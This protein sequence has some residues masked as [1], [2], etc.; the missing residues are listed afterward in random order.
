VVASGSLD[1]TITL[2]LQGRDGSRR[3]WTCTPPTAMGEPP[4][5]SLQ[6]METP[7]LTGPSA[8]MQIG[9]K[10]VD[11]EG[12]VLTVGTV[13]DIDSALFI[14]EHDLTAICGTENILMVGDLKDNVLSL[15]TH[16]GDVPWEISEGE[17]GHAESDTNAQEVC[18]RAFTVRGLEGTLALVVLS[19]VIMILTV[20]E[21][22]ET[23]GPNFRNPDSIQDC[24]KV[25]H[26]D[27]KVREIKAGTS[28]TLFFGLRGGGGGASRQ[29]GTKRNQR[30]R[31]MNFFRTCL[32]TI[33]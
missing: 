18:C 30:L 1:F 19:P 6:V 33:T 17:D 12:R 27:T 5:I 20:G 7:S 22:M 24:S 32:C 15:E 28:L 3:I 2:V 29:R 13:H 4:D 16:K 26:E 14:H 8:K 21:L 9:P 25:I 10:R 31:K 23:L 11:I